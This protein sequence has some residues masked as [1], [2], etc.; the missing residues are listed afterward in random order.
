MET[1]RQLL[2]SLDL[3]DQ[4]PPECPSSGRRFPDGGQY[5]IEIPE[6]QHVPPTTKLHRNC[7][8]PLMFSPR[9]AD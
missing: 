4:D 6:C 3:P 9:P 8:T 2:R 7:P 1:A 5:R